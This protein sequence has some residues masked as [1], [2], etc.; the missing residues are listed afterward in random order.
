MRLEI[1]RCRACGAPLKA[2]PADA[3]AR[4]GHCRAGHQ[5]IGSSAVAV[6]EA[7]VA[8]PAAAAVDQ[9]LPLWLVEFQVAAADIERLPPRS[10]FQPHPDES[11]PPP[12]PPAPLALDQ[13]QALLVPAFGTTNFVNYSS[14]LGLELSGRWD[15]RDLSPAPR[16]APWPLCRYGSL[17]ARGMAPVLLRLLVNKRERDVIGLEFEPVWIRERLIWWPF[18][19]DGDCLRDLL[20]GVRVLRSAIASDPTPA[21]A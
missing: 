13:R 20:F 8:P 9:W 15:G 14:N 17:D 6:S 7:A 2:D 4:C 11:V 12:D 10:V 21:D 16:D 5:I 1:L 19:V 3:M 18:A